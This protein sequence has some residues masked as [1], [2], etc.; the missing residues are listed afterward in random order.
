[1][2]TRTAGHFMFQ[3][4]SVMTEQSKYRAL[5][6]ASSERRLFL[7]ERR[8]PLKHRP[9]PG[10][11]LP[12]RFRRKY[13]AADLFALM[14]RGSLSLE[15]VVVLPLFLFAVLTIISFQEIYST[16]VM[17]LTRACT[18][19]MET[20]LSSDEDE[21]TISQ[22]YSFRP[23]CMFFCPAV[24]MENQVTVHAWSGADYETMTAGIP[25][26]KDEHMV[27]VTE[28]GSVVHEDA[29]CT[30]LDLSVSCV[31]GS[32][33]ETLRNAYGGKYHPC[34]I[35]S[36][37]GNPGGTVYITERG[38]RYHCLGSCSALKRTVRL[39]KQSETGEMRPCSRCGGHEHAE[40]SH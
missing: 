6:D 29:H 16:Q 27:Y 1:M 13:P 19:A 32:S 8:M 26:E 15:T 35:C 31:S 3:D 18:E 39:V 2:W 14:K 21:I 22:A 17:Q 7:Q 34:E 38:D 9:D 25:D 37:S 10:H 36:H 23:A 5:R 30:Y 33:V 4:L 24:P 12:G 28:H 11:S 20:G 40:D